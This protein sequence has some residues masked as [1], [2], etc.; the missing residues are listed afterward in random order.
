MI[1][2]PFGKIDMVFMLLSRRLLRCVSSGRWMFLRAV[3]V[4][5]LALGSLALV[6][7][8]WEGRGLREGRHT[9]W[10]TRF[11]FLILLDAQAYSKYGK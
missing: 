3:D 8:G 6:F 9:A 11:S 10:P 5:V 1:T 4:G 2:L 7:I